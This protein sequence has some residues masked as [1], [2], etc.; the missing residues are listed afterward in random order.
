MK[1]QDKGPT[2][3]SEIAYLVTLKSKLVELFRPG[4]D[5]VFAKCKRDDLGR[6]VYE[7][8]PMEGLASKSAGC[9]KVQVPG[10]NKK[11]LKTG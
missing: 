5:L 6:H 3:E 2:T 9:Y 1:R 7:P 10:G 11:G 8:Q 4:Y